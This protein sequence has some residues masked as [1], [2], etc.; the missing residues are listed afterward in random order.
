MIG[1]EL[2]KTKILNTTS[3]FIILVGTEGMGKSTLIKELYPQIKEIDP[4]VEGIRNY[5]DNPRG[6]YY[7]PNG[8]KLSDVAI[9]S[10]L[11]TM[12]DPIEG[13]LLFMEVRNV[14]NIPITLLSRANIIHLQPYKVEDINKYIDD[15]SINPCWGDICQSIGEVI[16]YS[17]Y[18]YTDILELA[19]TYVTKYKK[20][21]IGNLLNISNRLALK[22][23]SNL[24]PPELFLKMIMKLTKEYSVIRIATQALYELTLVSSTPSRV[25]DMFFIGCRL[26]I[27]EGGGK[28]K[29]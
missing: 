15:N 14:E 10:L 13:Q 6:T 22:K 16:K 23:D 26:G 17:K 18:E 29:L 21:S 5:I 9:A 8:N 25:M 20:T 28:W 7:I 3:K 24:I 4:G 19:E 1:Q 12:E 27:K 2:V 11:I